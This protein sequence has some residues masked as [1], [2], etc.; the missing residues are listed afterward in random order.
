MTGFS[1][2]LALDSYWW[3]WSFATLEVRFETYAR[4]RW[5]G[6]LR[7][8]NSHYT[9]KSPRRTNPLTDSTNLSSRVRTS[10]KLGCFP[11][12]GK[13]LSSLLGSSTFHWVYHQA[14]RRCV[15]HSLRVMARTCERRRA[16]SRVS[17]ISWDSHTLE[18]VRVAQVFS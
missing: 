5:I 8:G 11:L 17:R 18:M 13:D 15:D 9:R 4:F 16:Q 7:Y 3:C 14:E 2:H 10:I 12:H 6:L 1:S